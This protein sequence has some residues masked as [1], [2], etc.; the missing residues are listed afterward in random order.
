MK[1][2]VWVLILLFLEIS[3]LHAQ[4]T[5]KELFLQV[6]SAWTFQKLQLIPFRFHQAGRAQID[7]LETAKPLLSLKDAMEAGKIKVAE[8]FSNHDADIRVLT[9]K[10]LSKQAIIINQGDLLAGGKQDR[11]VA[12]TKVLAPGTEEF[13]NVF[14]VEPGRWD[15]KPKPFRFAGSADLALRNTMLATGRQS[16]IWKAIEKQFGVGHGLPEGFNYIDKQQQLSDS[17]K[18][19]LAYFK[20]R[21]RYS[22]SSFAGFLAITG[23]KVIGCEL[24]SDQNF[25]LLSMDNIFQAAIAQALQIGALPVMKVEEIAAIIKPLIESEP[26]QKYFLEKHGKAFYYRN[27]IVHI[28]VYDW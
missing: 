24:F 15:T 7:L 16:E 18:I 8:F 3:L 23:N 27:R 17:A 6:D 28:T 9:V 26:S 11:M 19:Y 10:N 22:D 12:E 5:S 2:I 25:T 14:C 1:R 4:C 13:L 20:E 21:L